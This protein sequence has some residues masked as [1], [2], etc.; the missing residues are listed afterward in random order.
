MFIHW[1]TALNTARTA[2]MIAPR[3]FSEN[4]ALISKKNEA[5]QDS[6]KRANN[7]QT[8]TIFIN[9]SINNLIPNYEATNW[10]EIH[11]N[12]HYTKNPTQVDNFRSTALWLKW[13]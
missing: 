3:F 8:L 13:F 11:K 9:L 1:I 10:Y 5:I 12:F 7:A 4:I 6:T 2:D